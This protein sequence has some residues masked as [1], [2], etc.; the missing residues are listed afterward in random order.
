MK[1]KMRNTETGS[2][3]DFGTAN[4]QY[5]CK[6]GHEYEVPDALGEAWVRKGIATKVR[7]PKAEAPKLKKGV[8]RGD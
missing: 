3:P 8:K 4:D 7:V 5:H 1:V 2:Y 6:M